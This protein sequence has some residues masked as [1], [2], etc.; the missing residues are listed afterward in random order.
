MN[1]STLLACVTVL[2]IEVQGSL[3]FQNL[4][5]LNPSPSYGHVHFVVDTSIIMKQL[6]SIDSAISYVRKSVHTIT[7][8]NVEHRAK[9]FLLKAH[10]DIGAMINEFQDLSQIVNESTS[11][12]S[13]VKRFLGL[14]LAIGSISLSLFNQAE[15]LHLQGEISDVVTR[16]NHIV[17][18]LQEHEVAVHKLQ[19]DVLQIR[20]G[21]ISLSNIVE[22]SSAIAKIHDAEIEIVMALAELR[23]T[24][25]CVQGGIQQLLNHRL[26]ICFLNT[27]QVRI[28]LDK[29]FLSAAS[30]SLEPVSRHLS[31]FLQFETSFLLIKGK[32]HVYV[33]VPLINRKLLLDL[34]RFNNAP[35]QVSSTL[36]LQF[37]P[38]DN[39]LA[40]GQDGLHTTL[41]QEDVAQYTKYGRYFFANNAVTLN[42][43]LNMTCLGTI[44][45]QDHVNIRKVCPAKFSTASE[46]FINIAP[47][48]YLFY[49]A[50]PQTLQ[51]H[52]KS[53]IRHI[54]VKQ[55]ENIRLDNNCEVKSKQSLTRTGHN[56][57]VE[58]AIN[59]WPAAWNVSGLLF[60]L[61]T[62]TL[63]EQVK[64]LKLI[65]YPA[66]PI[67]DLHL[68]IQQG[69]HQET[70]HV[71]MTAAACIAASLV[72]LI[73]CYLGYRYY[74]IHKQT[75]TQT[76][77]TQT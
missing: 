37:A 18:I 16:Q 76:P 5:Q 13:R 2:V 65:N 10:I 12:Q 15:I 23:R 1:L 47:G 61:D 36:T 55:S 11:N 42:L 29:L 44:Y 58:S 40:I 43:D 4:G 75:Q 3:Y 66:M 68:L 25:L 20:D 24:M 38:T 50:A 73:F 22:E 35:T 63:T 57:N 7:H 54:A 49:T 26:P 62:S 70:G 39:V 9:N 69:T 30:Q 72:I 60:D 74:N 56:M 28:S 45:S 14:L 53:G 17:D 27:T 48:E 8:R 21:F 67:P 77:I 19:H 52:C 31:A 33:H 64:K 6:H 41:T 46:M 71:W 34:M 32:I 59:R 51:V